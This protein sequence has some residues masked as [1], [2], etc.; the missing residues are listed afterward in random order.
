[1]ILGKKWSNF[2]SCVTITV[3][4]LPLGCA[5]L[6]PVPT[7]PPFSQE[8]ATSLVTHLSEEGRDVT[9]FQGAGKIMFKKGEEESTSNLLAVGA[10]PL[11]VRLEMTHSWGKPLL[12][13][14]V[15][16]ENV[17]VLS[18]VDKKFYRGRSGPSWEKT[19][20]LLGLDPDSVWKILSGRVPVLTHRNA[21]SLR[22]NEITLYDGR[23]EV[24][25]VISFLA[26]PRV[27]RSVSFPK[28]G[29][30]VTLSEFKQR[31]QGPSPLKISAARKD[32][33]QLLEIHYKR[34]TLNRPIPEEIF[35]LNPPP[36]FEVIEL[37]Q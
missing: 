28:K 5:R 33:G 12:H 16:S 7:T 8:E 19:F 6:I 3:V 30:T 22:S 14:V 36:G 17:L 29:I 4:I 1:L 13:I 37:D 21:V 25:E 23:G 10:K 24:V 11:K 20:F 15:D 9:S 32:G 18:L 2:L 26:E 35:H 31:E 34:L 27:P